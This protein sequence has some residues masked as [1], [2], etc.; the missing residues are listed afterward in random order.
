MYQCV[1]SRYFCICIQY[2]TVR[3]GAFALIGETEFTRCEINL[4][5]VFIQF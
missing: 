5:C 4:Y 2:L 1:P 3:I